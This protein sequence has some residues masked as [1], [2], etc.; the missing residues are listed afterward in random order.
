MPAARSVTI[1]L[2]ALTVAI[3][4]TE[5]RA[6]Q[7]PQSVAAQIEHLVA[8]LGHG[9]QPSA[10]MVQGLTAF[11]EGQGLAGDG[12]SARILEIG[13]APKPAE[14]S[15][16]SKH[17]TGVQGTAVRKLLV[18]ERRA[19]GPGK[20]EPVAYV[21]LKHG[22]GGPI[23]RIFNGHISHLRAVP[24][25]GSFQ[26]LA[27]T[28]RHARESA[29]DSFGERVPELSGV[30]RPVNGKLERIRPNRLVRRN[31]RFAQRR[32]RR[33]MAALRTSMSEGVLRYP[34]AM[35]RG[36]REAATRT[37]RAIRSSS[38]LTPSGDE[39]QAK[40]D[41]AR[42]RDKKAQWDARQAELV[43]KVQPTD[44]SRGPNVSQRYQESIRNKQAALGKARRA[45]LVRPAR[46][47][48]T[49][50][51]RTAQ[52]LYHAATSRIGSLGHPAPHGA[53]Q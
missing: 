16:E 21:E 39:R 26:L 47:L 8:R 2:I 10:L 49:P 20:K 19:N 24:F 37:I 40:L 48:A 27:R 13:G 22:L 31:L 42:L 41:I 6:E 45:R 7:E 12:I 44:P 33:V 34:V 15:S 3:L 1:R 23:A 29:A 11:L 53:A 5:A 52:R 46:Q 14:P 9:Q 35:Q 4:P 18:L 43:R 38:L 30:F 36:L 50:V 17:Q 51:S 32:A 25:G 28:R